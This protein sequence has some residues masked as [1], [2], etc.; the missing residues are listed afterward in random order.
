MRRVEP[1]TVAD[2]VTPAAIETLATRSNLRLGREIV[3]SGGVE[4][5]EFE[6]LRV[7]AK[8]TGGQRR[9]VELL[10][11]QGELSWRCSCTKRADL[12]CKHCVAAA[13]AAWEMAPHDVSAGQSDQRGAA[14]TS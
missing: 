11:D 1:P 8:V 4:F 3:A 5:Q 2:L 7:W 6:P 13:L 10:S 14:L 12:I 9:N